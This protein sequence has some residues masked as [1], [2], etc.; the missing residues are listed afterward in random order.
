MAMKN[1]IIEMVKK[2][3]GGKSAVAAFLGMKECEFNNRLY[4]TK[5]QRFTEEELIAIETEYGVSDW[6]DEL[7]RRLGKVSFAIPNADELDLVELS[8]LQL[9]ERA[10]SGVFFAKLDEFVQDGVLT[11]VEQDILRKLL[12]R[13]Q[14]AKAK[15]FESA[16]VIFSK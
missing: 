10:A 7:N 9:H 12:H 1:V 6:S 11:N 4:Q 13:S 3:Q 2:C 14:T 8:S 15:M 16:V 5:G